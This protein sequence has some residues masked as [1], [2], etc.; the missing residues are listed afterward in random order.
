MLYY[1]FQYLDQLDFPDTKHSDDY[2]GK[3]NDEDNENE[4]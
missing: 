3:F 1:L 4:K 2:H